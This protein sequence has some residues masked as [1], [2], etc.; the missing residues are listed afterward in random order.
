MSEPKVLVVDDEENISFLV[1][2]ALR[3]A[4]MDVETAETGRSAMSLA[5]SFRPDVL[6]LDIMLGDVDGLDVLRTLRSRGHTAPV[7]FL[8]AKTST[9]D[10]VKGLTL[11]LIHI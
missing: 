2:S 5:D 11:S 7:L 10:R 3:M 1:A 9:A 4:G 8:T 6:V